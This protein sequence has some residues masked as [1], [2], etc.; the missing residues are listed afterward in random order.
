MAKCWLLMQLLLALLLPAAISMAAACHPHDLHALQGFA[1]N[2]SGGAVLL[3]ATWTGASCCGWE[4]VGCNG[5]KSDGRVTTLLLPGRG[6][7]GP[8]LGASSL[9][10]LAQLES[11][12][13]AHNRLQVGSTFPLWIGEL[14][15]LR[16]LDLSHNASPLHVNSSN[17]RTLAEGQPNTISGTNNSVRS[18]SGNT[19]MGEDNIVIS[20]DNNVVSGKQNTVTGSDNVVSGSNNSVSGSHNTV[21]G[22]NHVVS[23]DNKV[24][25]GG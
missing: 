9:A 11:L 1:G 5:G 19:V 16:Y 15:H 20:G 25:T 17:R 12:N 3:R 4:G 7:T 23:G 6:L 10:G 13:L 8:I 2:L 24:V 14:G 22:S 18:G 21:S